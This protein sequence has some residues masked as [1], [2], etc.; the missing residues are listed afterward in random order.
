MDYLE[1]ARRIFKEDY[2]ATEAA[3]IVIDKVEPGYAKCT[4]PLGTIHKNAAGNVMGGAVFTLADFAFGVAANTEERVSTV[5]LTSEIRF[6]GFSKGSV[7]TA[8]ARRIREGKS[9]AFY[10]VEVCDDLGTVVAKV[11]MTGARKVFQA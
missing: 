7:L 3:G 10:D 2:F 8:E 4:M 6:I 9:V 1:N 5:S 11:A